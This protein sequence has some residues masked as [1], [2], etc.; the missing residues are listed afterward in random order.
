M[1]GIAMPPSCCGSP[2]SSSGILGSNRLVSFKSCSESDGALLFGAVRKRGHHSA[3]CIRPP[4]RFFHCDA[5]FGQHLWRM[6]KRGRRWFRARRPGKPYLPIRRNSPFETVSGTKIAIQFTL[7]QDI[8]QFPDSDFQCFCIGTA[9]GGGREE[10]PE[11][12]GLSI[13][14]DARHPRSLRRLSN[15]RHSGFGCCIGCCSVEQ[16]GKC[17]FNGPFPSGRGG[18]IG[19]VGRR[20]S[21]AFSGSRHF[22]ASFSRDNL[23]A[24]SFA[25][26]LT[27]RGTGR[28][29]SGAN[30]SAA[31]RYIVPAGRQGAVAANSLLFGRIGISKRRMRGENDQGESI[32]PIFPYGAPDNHS[33]AF[34]ARISRR[35]DVLRPPIC[36]RLAGQPN[37]G[38]VGFQTCG[39]IDKP[40]F[41]SYGSLNHDGETPVRCWARGGGI[42]STNS[43]PRSLLSM[44][45]YDK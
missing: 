3:S 6:T 1:D 30:S 27:C 43:P 41:L 40:R 26:L 39:L 33:S 13:Y 7:R 23:A 5:M 20:Q 42:A 34:W 15:A 38:V 2:F 25:N 31:S 18:N 35:A 10:R 36:Q 21:F 4:P 28:R 24:L 44:T 11:I 37:V 17:A 32:R 9:G 19:P 29:Q 8:L 14:L 16:S 12:L 45:G 22:R